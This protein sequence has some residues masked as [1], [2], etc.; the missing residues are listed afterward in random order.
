MPAYTICLGAINLYKELYWKYLQVVSVINRNF[1]HCFSS[2][3][4]VVKSFW[5]PCFMEIRLGNKLGFTYF[6]RALHMRINSS[7]LW[8][9]RW[10]W[11]KQVQMVSMTITQK[12]MLWTLS[13]CF[14]V[15]LSEYKSSTSIY[16]KH[17]L[18]SAD[19]W[20]LWG[21]RIRST[22]PLRLKKKKIKQTK[23]TIAMRVECSGSTEPL[24]PF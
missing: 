23:K 14:S 12:T 7:A 13:I 3:Q 9:C 16:P 10:E 11:V 18:T 2:V 19:I 20:I 15:Y 24:F 21:E 1:W 17:P 8:D 6:W 5:Y 22:W 4:V